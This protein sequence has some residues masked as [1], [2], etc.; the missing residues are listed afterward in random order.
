MTAH[1]VYE[2]WKLNSKIINFCHLP[3]PHTGAELAKIVY[4]FLEDWGIEKKIFSLTLDSASTN[5]RMAETLKEIFLNNNN[6]LL[7]GGEF[8]HVRCFEHSNY[9]CCIGINI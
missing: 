8:L 4:E 3:P 6:G 2:D 7:C 9:N 1:F 5:G